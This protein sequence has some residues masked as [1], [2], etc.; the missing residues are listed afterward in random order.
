[1]LTVLGFLA[2]KKGV[3]L[4]I[5]QHRQRAAVRPYAGI[6]ATAYGWAFSRAKKEFIWKSPSTGRERRCGLMRVLLLLLMAGL[7][8]EQKRSLFGNHPAPAESGGAYAGIAATGI[9]EG[10]GKRV[11][12]CE[13]MIPN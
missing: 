6:A 12:R 9:N 7:S 4:E 2:S 1:V 10:R 13:I 3:Y 5:T 11:P 8:R